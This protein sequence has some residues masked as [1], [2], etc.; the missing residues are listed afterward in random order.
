MQY[1]STRSNGES[2]DSTKAV[3]EGLSP[4]G[5]LY[6][7]A[8]FPEAPDFYRSLIGKTFA[9]M[10]EAVFSLFLDDFNDIPGIVEKAYSGKFDT[11]EITPLKKVG[12]RFKKGETLCYIEAMKVQNAVAADFDG[13]ISAILKSNGESVEEDEVILKVSR[14]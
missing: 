5:G 6:M 1:R 4:D 9:E 2:V 10:A 8:V 3:L 13:V 12:D 7:P 14:A 11:P